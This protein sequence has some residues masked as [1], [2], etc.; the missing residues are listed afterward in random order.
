ME[1][2]SIEDRLVVNHK[3]LTACVVRRA[4]KSDAGATLKINLTALG[5]NWE[6][7]ARAPTL[8]AQPY[9]SATPTVAASIRSRMHWP[10]PA[11]KRFLS[12]TLLK[13]DAFVP[14]RRI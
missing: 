5:F 10:N 3:G 1:K 9:L 14:Q 7:L 2:S 8:N 12:P 11:A 13:P 6:R 4:L